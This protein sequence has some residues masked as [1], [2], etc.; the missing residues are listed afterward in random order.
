MEESQGQS[1]AV[2]ESAAGPTVP[3]PDKA[4]RSAEPASE[5]APVKAP[6]PP[7]PAQSVIGKR[8]R[9]SAQ[10]A[11]S[12]A[13]P[14]AQAGGQNTTAGEAPSSKREKRDHPTPASSPTKNAS[15][16]SVSANSS[17]RKQAVALPTAAAATG[18]AGDSSSSQTVA[19]EAQSA[20]TSPASKRP[21]RKAKK[22]AEL[23]QQQQ[24]KAQEQ[25]AQQQQ[26]QQ[27]ATGNGSQSNTPR[28]TAVPLPQAEQSMQQHMPQSHQQKQPDVASHQQQQQQHQQ[29]P[30]Q[31]NL[32]QL[33]QDIM[34]LEANVKSAT[35]FRAN[36][37][38]FEKLAPENR[39]A[40]MQKIG[41][42]EAQL[43][44][45]KGVYEWHI[46]QRSQQQGTMPPQQPQQ[47]QQDTFAA[48]HMHARQASLTQQQP[49][50]QQMQNG[51]NNTGS[52]A[53]AANAASPASAMTPQA[54]HLPL[55][56]PQ[57]GN[58]NRQQQPIRQPTL[59]QQQQQQQQGQM[60]PP[61]QPGQQQQQQY[62]QN[63]QDPTAGPSGE[64][65]NT[66]RTRD[67]RLMLSCSDG[68]A[69]HVPAATA[70]ASL[71]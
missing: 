35:S 34:R 65:R 14:Q 47:M 18:G 15:F 28:Q 20:N 67:T 64:C 38:M 8:T 13:Q 19:T 52:P 43:G 24:Q 3:Q 70:T 6:S 33:A 7:A 25:T 55:Q 1:Q 56:S 50:H 59:Q 71:G 36:T 58:L 66:S 32:D 17:P 57:L 27:S 37:A 9:S 31:I 10:E 4:E 49:Q 62:Q 29:Q 60:G 39:H 48:P 26:Q 41:E 2:P 69:E 68:P 40:M 16:G 22:P 45:M 5:A 23:Q 21:T 30:P 42:M 61:A 12:Q 63:M 44:Q 53:A 11:N 46:R 51:F 54:Q